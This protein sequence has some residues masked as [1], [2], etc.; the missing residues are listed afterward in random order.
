MAEQAKPIEKYKEFVDV[1]VKSKAGLEAHSFTDYSSEAR[2]QQTIDFIEMLVTHIGENYPKNPALAVDGKNRLTEYFFHQYNKLPHAEEAA[3]LRQLMARLL[4]KQLEISKEQLVAE[5]KA[6]ES[7]GVGENSNE[8]R[9]LAE[10]NLINNEFYR[11]L[12]PGCHGSLAVFELMDTLAKRSRGPFAE[13]ARRLTLDQKLRALV[14]SLGDKISYVRA[15]KELSP[16]SMAEEIQVVIQ[17]YLEECSTPGDM[18]TR[19][20]KP[21]LEKLKDS[22]RQHQYRLNA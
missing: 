11:Q 4:I 10:D 21:T 1:A 14:D 18:V 16:S 7:H 6:L 12:A 2:R 5:Q 3:P 22:G 19:I 20:L 13:D 15:C 17:R 9:I 8:S